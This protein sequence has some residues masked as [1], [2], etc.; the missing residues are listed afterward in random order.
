M[1]TGVLFIESISLLIRWGL[2]V[3]QTYYI[4]V[5]CNTAVEEIQTPFESSRIMWTANCDVSSERIVRRI[6]GEIIIYTIIDTRVD[7]L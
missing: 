3:H 2:S 6:N 5:H 1:E 7:A 4:I